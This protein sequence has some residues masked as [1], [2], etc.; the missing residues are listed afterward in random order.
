MSKNKD[1][2]R[3]P[4]SIV[5][6]ILIAV[7]VGFGTTFVIF[8]FISND[9]FMNLL[10]NTPKWIFLLG[11]LGYSTIYVVNAIQNKIILWR[12]R[13]KMSFLALIRNSILG[14]FFDFVTPFAMGGQPYTIYDFTKHG[15]SSMAASNTVI[16]RFLSRNVIAITICLAVYVVF[17]KI[18]ISL[19]I[20]GGVFLAGFTISMTMTLLILVFTVS[21]RIKKKFFKILHLKFFKK[22]FGVGHLTPE[23]IESK[24]D[25]KVMEF[26]T[27]LKILWK[28]NLGY[29]ILEAILQVISTVLQVLILYLFI[30]YF[31]D[32]SLDY[33]SFI[34]VLLMHFAMGYVVYYAPTPGSSGAIETIYLLILG[35]S[36]FTSSVNKTPILVAIISWRI[37]TYYI[38]M[39]VGMIVFFVARRNTTNS[40]NTEEELSTKPN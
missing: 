19:G 2:K 20:G 22:I 24:I 5:R 25:S 16:S 21:N 30:L 10:L 31:V 11:F 3:S 9:S 33:P 29:M 17:I 18:F 36:F 40:Q 13:Q 1:N 38:P 35:S 14:F 37:S 6:N 8:K 15:V 28:D 39:F 23:Q 34:E 7:L 32:R 12:L 4:L 26:R 27:S